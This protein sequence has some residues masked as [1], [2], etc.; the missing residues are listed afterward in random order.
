M[1]VIVDN[2]I[3]VRQV[4]KEMIKAGFGIT[5]KTGIKDVLIFPEEEIEK[6]FNEYKR[7][8]EDAMVEEMFEYNDRLYKGDGHMLT[9]A[10]LSIFKE[11]LKLRR[12]EEK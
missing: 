9:Q 7:M 1:V 8:V 11:H 3:F 5:T 10:F 4:N 6:I 12:K 2:S